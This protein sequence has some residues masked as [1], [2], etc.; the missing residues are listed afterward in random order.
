MMLKLGLVLSGL[1][2]TNH[3]LEEDL[4]FLFSLSH[5][6]W[7]FRIYCY[8]LYGQLC[9]KKNETLMIFLV[10]YLIIINAQGEG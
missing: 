9:I 1:L 8:F 2:F 3:F 6:P 5:F 10:V 4:L 7:L